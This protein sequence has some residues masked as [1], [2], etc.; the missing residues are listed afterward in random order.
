MSIVCHR[1][2]RRD[3]DGAV[4]DPYQVRLDVIR[5]PVFSGPFDSFHFDSKYSREYVDL[6]LCL[7]ST[8]RDLYPDV[9]AE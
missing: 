8:I 1:T 3:Y 2:R 5:G 9:G 4:V 6:Y 7:P